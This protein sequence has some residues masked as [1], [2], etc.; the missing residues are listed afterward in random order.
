MALSALPALQVRVPNPANALLQAEQIIGARAQRNALM[1]QEEQRAQIAQ[2]FAGGIPADRAGQQALVGRVA[3]IDPQQAL[4]F[5]QAFNQLDEQSQA[6]VARESQLISRVFA[7]VR[8]PQGYAQGRALLQQQGVDIS[9]LPAEYNPQAISQ[10]VNL[11][12]SVDSIIA[13]QKPQFTQVGNQIVRIQDGQVTP[14]FT[15]PAGPATPRTVLAQI[16]SDLVNGLITPAQAM[17]LAQ[18]ATAPAER[19]RPIT[20]AERGLF[21]IPDGQAAQISEATGKVSTIGPAGVEVNVDLSNK[22]QGRIEEDI[23]NTQ[24]A[25]SRVERIRN[26]FDP[27]FQQF[28]PRL[29]IKWNQLVARFSELSPDARERVEARAV[30]QQNSIENVNSTIR[31]LTG[32]QMSQFEA[33]RI[34]SQLPNPGTGLFDGDDPVT[35]EAK[36]NNSLES[37]RVVLARRAYA[38]ATGRAALSTG[39]DLD[40]TVAQIVNQRGQE[41]ED[42]FRSQGLSGQELNSRVDARLRIEFGGLLNAG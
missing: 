42:L 17:L 2:Q 19:F 11:S 21:G 10:L 12:R 37:L 30:F 6:Q 9:K 33:Q 28:F 39:F 15:A 14:V 34:T 35:F 27:T 13:E 23:L 41:L 31:A 29:G 16:N 40:S 7:D 8:D 38:E 25:I 4:Q 26:S 36:M 3:A 22:T 5:Q 18:Q 20:D 24:D 1:R 32:A